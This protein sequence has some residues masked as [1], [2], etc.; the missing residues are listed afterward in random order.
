MAS[1]N[2]RDLAWLDL[3]W[4]RREPATRGPKPTL[5]VAQIAQ[6]GVKLADEEGLSA[7]SM[8]RIATALNVGTM[9]LYNY[10]PDK[11]GLL[12]LMLDSVSSQTPIPDHTVGWRPF[13]RD[14]A[15]ALL[16]MYEDHPWMADVRVEGPPIG[17]SQVRFI[18]SA[19]GSFQDTGLSGQEAMAATMSIQ[20]FVLGMAKLGIH[21]INDQRAAAPIEPAW[22]E[23]FRHVLDPDE[24]PRTLAVMTAVGPT[25]HKLTWDDLGFG[26][27]L[28]RLLDGIASHID[29]VSRLR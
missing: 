11:A 5:Q 28:E 3:L 19:M 6:A 8:K 1:R 25:P 29:S 21:M 20:A 9:T 23:A 2:G 27:G 24:F 26:F 10:V 14:S 7:V 13:L 16:A 12:E 4:G 22:A 17:P 18:E 15:Q